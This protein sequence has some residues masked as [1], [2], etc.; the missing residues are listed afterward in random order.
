MLVEDKR[1]VFLLGYPQDINKEKVYKAI[2]L[3]Y[4]VVAFFNS[5][6]IDK[7]CRPVILDRI[8]G[9][10]PPDFQ[11]KN[12][13]NQEERTCQRKKYILFSS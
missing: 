4:R 13:E 8:R 5:T 11:S 1:R 10:P 9:P 12:N 2:I 3:I 6:K 7:A